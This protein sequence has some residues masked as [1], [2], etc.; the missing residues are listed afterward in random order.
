MEEV[1]NIE[2]ESEDINKFNPIQIPIELNKIEY[3][4]KVNSIKSV[5]A[6]ELID[7]EKMPYINYKRKMDFKEIKEMNQLFNL[8]KT[9]NDFY[10]YLKLLSK[11]KK[12]NIRK[13]KDKISIILFIDVLSKQQ[14]IIID[15][16]PEENQLEAN[17]KE[18]EF[19]NINNTNICFNYILNVIFLII[20]SFFI[21]YIINSKFIKKYIES[22]ENT[23]EILIK[24]IEKQIKELKDKNEKQIKELNKKIET[25][26][27]EINNLQI[28][29][30]YLDKFGLRFSF[31]NQSAIIKGDEKNFIFREIENKMNKK[32]KEI[33]KLYQATKD[34]GDPKIFH[35]KCDNIPNTLVLIK[36]EDNKRFGGFT[37]IPWS[38]NNSGKKDNK[39]MTFVFSLDNKKIYFLK[40]MNSIAVFHNEK[41]GPYFGEY[42]DMAILGNPIKDKCLKI[43]GDY[44]NIP[45]N[46]SQSP[47][48]ALE[49][50]V[51]RTEFY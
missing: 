17:R 31:F 36:S 47:M 20:I 16:F 15:L 34:G 21:L 6:F 13:S 28:L 18:K 24:K 25:Q 44:Y 43:K 49:Y 40:K 9:N 33:K 46:K 39:N 12:I 35:L 51:F 27:K 37:P 38:S 14:E 32:I 22:K 30:I 50:E 11:N 8:L 29:L 4:L 2:S 3:I 26:N 7:I 42:E 23:N 19:N 48:K 41:F 5:F 10:D 45:L 1:P